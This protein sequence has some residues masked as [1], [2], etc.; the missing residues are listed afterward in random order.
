MNILVRKLVH[1]RM[2][3]LVHNNIRWHAGAWELPSEQFEKPISY[4][5]QDRGASFNSD[6]AP[7]ARTLGSD[8][9]RRRALAFGCVGIAWLSRGATSHARRL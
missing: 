2:E 7:I 3:R 9:G 6:L 1:S 5:W 4:D 8:L